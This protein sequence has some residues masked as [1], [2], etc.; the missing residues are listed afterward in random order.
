MNSLGYSDYDIDTI[1]I[2]HEI[3]KISSAF[4]IINLIYEQAIDDAHC[5]V[6]TESGTYE[7]LENLYMEAEQRKSQAV[8]GVLTRIAQA[9]EDIFGRIIDS[10][11]KFLT[12]VRTKN[13]NELVEYDASLDER[14]KDGNTILGKLKSL[15]NIGSKLAFGKIL[16]T[17]IA[18]LLPIVTKTYVK[19]KIKKAAANKVNALF[20]KAENMSKNL[21]STIGG[22][23]HKAT[24]EDL[25]DGEAQGF[26]GKALSWAGGLLSATAVK[27]GSGNSN[28][29]TANTN[30][31]T[32]DTGNNNANTGNNNAGGI[33]KSAL[34]NVPKTTTPKE[35]TK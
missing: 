2:E 5:K 3:S 1:I 18:F 12:G 28:D 8:G 32:D 24:G 4:R 23:F 19:R 33:D 15:L 11:T 16:G 25:K 9:F 7:D 29:G 20:D 17:V 27:K 10:I 34:A 6:F 13:P 22:V 21:K 14:L 30:S 26:W 31:G 35:D